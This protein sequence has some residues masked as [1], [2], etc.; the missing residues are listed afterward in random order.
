MSRTRLIVAVVASAVLA[1]PMVTFVSALV[2]FPLLF[3]AGLAI[4]ACYAPLAILAT[5]AFERNGPRLRTARLIETWQYCSIIWVGCAF[6]LSRWGYAASSMGGRN[7]P[8]LKV[9]L[10]PYWLVY[11]YV[12]S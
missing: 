8:Y 2:V 4:V 5:S 6:G 1:V 12:R 11:E 10:F 7:E 3:Y 9:L